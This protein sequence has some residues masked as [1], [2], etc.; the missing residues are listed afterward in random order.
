MPFFA[1]PA[2]PLIFCALSYPAVLLFFFALTLL[3]PYFSL[4]LVTLLCL[5]FLAY[6]PLRT[7]KFSISKSGEC[8]V[9]RG[10]IYGQRLYNPKDTAFSA[11]PASV[12]THP[13]RGYLPV[14]GSYAFQGTDNIDVMP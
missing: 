7:K 11:K 1:Y 2:V 3:C 10:R 13:R 5:Y 12:L 6:L 4:R 9:F 14:P 8:G